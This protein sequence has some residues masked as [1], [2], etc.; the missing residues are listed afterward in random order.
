[1]GA[2]RRI[3]SWY[4]A[5]LVDTDLPLP[6]DRGTRLHAYHQFVVRVPHRQR[7]QEKMT[8]AGVGTAIHYPTPIHLQPAAQGVCK[9]PVTPKKA[10]EFAGQILSLPMFASLTEANVDY[11]ATAL[12]GAL[13]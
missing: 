8:T 1:V 3:A 4:R 11:V 5:A 2:R 7:V 6:A 12:K 13:K 9:V 10:E